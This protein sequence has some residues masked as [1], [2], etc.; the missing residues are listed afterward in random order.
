MELGGSSSPP[1]CV[2]DVGTESDKVDSAVGHVRL[3]V[4]R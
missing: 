1:G 4:G 2:L 3:I